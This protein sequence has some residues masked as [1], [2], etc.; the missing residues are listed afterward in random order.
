MTCQNLILSQ[1]EEFRRNIQEKYINDFEE[2]CF[3]DSVE[4]EAFSIFDPSKLPASC[5]DISSYGNDNL[6]L[7]EEKCVSDDADFQVDDLAFRQLL[8][9]VNAKY[10]LTD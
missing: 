1:K 8:T 9:R 7:L 5:T 10:T 6:A 3:S 4:V 2:N